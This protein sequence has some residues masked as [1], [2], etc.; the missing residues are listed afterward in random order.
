[1]DHVTPSS[2]EHILRNGTRITHHSFFVRRS[3]EYIPVTVHYITLFLV[4]STLHYDL[5]TVGYIALEWYVYTPVLAYGYKA[6]TGR[7]S[8]NIQV[9]K[10]RQIQQEMSDSNQEYILTISV[11]TTRYDREMPHE[12][13]IVFIYI[14]VVRTC[15]TNSEHQVLISIPRIERYGASSSSRI[16]EILRTIALSWS[17][18]AQAFNCNL[19]ELR[20]KRQCSSSTSENT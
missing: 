2:D 8:T 11:T 12:D 16:D 9:A 13:M 5:S 19:M 4:W 20:L 1:M 14:S 7:I 17:S 3:Y 15:K 18:I 6:V 10:R